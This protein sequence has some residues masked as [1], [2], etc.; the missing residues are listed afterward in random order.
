MHRQH[1]ARNGTQQLAPALHAIHTVPI[2]V[3]ISIEPLDI[4]ATT[5]LPASPMLI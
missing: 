4:S 5:L 1:V 2:G 3:V